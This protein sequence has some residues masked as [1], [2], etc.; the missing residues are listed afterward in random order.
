[1]GTIYV[2][3]AHIDGHEAIQ[4]HDKQP[5]KRFYCIIDYP[6]LLNISAGISIT[7]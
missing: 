4:M 3:S 7:C 5:A 1:M 6:N 2:I